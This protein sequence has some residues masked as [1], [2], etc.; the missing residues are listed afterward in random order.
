MKNEFILDSERKK[1]NITLSIL[2]WL[3]FLVPVAYILQPIAFVFLTEYYESFKLNVLYYYSAQHFYAAWTTDFMQ[4]SAIVLSFL[5]VVFMAFFLPYK[6]N[7]KQLK[8]NP[9]QDLKNLVRKHLELLLFGFI[10]LWAAISIA[11][12]SDSEIAYNGFP[13]DEH[14]FKFY[15]MYIPLFTSI[16]FLNNK[17]KRLL[18]DSIVI[19]SLAFVIYEFV[20]DVCGVKVLNDSGEYVNKYPVCYTFKWCAIFRNRNFYGYFLSFAIITPAALFFISKKRVLQVYYLIAMVLNLFILLLNKCDGAFLGVIGGLIFILCSFSMAKKKFEK[21]ALIPI[22]VFLVFYAIFEISGLTSYSES[23]IKIFKDLFKLSKA[24]EYTDTE[25]DHLGSN[26]IK[27]WKDA[28]YV[29]KVS[30]LFG[31][32]IDCYLSYSKI[33]PGTLQIPHN[34]YLQVGQNMG[35]PAMLAYVASLIYIFVKSIINRKNLTQMQ[36]VALSAGFAY[37]ISA[38]FGNSW[39]YMVPYVLFLVAMSLGYHVSDIEYMN[40]E[41]KKEYYIKLLEDS[42][43]D[44]TF[45]ISNTPLSANA[46]SQVVESDNVAPL[47]STGPINDIHNS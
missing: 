43:K 13:Y 30:P 40:E 42:T 47:D 12:A 8:L 11:F 34:E 2:R 26:R 27:L 38:F 16:F 32:G 14:G 5:I 15:L 29:M 7:T 9:K 6:V 4:Y 17:Q 35:I 22:A 21:K 3:I 25:I 28:F 1:I 23:F 33:I 46:V 41:E 45:N 39:A 24:N 31:N 18:L 37:F 36:L 44:G 19:L 20:L 10:L